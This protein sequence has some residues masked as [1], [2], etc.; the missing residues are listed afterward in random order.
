MLYFERSTTFASQDS[1]IWVTLR[2]GPE[3]QWSV[4][5]RAPAGI[6]SERAEF[7]PSLSTDGNTLY[8]ASE[9][10]GSLGPIPLQVGRAHQ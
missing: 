2:A 10:C 7:S 4:P 9:R 1:D 5:Q 3:D 8:L 6:N